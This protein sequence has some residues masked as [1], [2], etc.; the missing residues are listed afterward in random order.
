MYYLRYR[1]LYH[2]YACFELCNV[3]QIIPVVYFK[4]FSYR[5]QFNIY[6]T[7]FK[8]EAFLILIGEY[9]FH[10]LTRFGYD[11]LVRLLGGNI[12]EFVQNLDSIQNYLRDDYQDTIAP[13]FHCD[14]ESVSD[15]MILHYYSHRP[16]YHPL[17]RGK[18][19]II[20]H[21][22]GHHPFISGLEIMNNFK[23]DW[24]I[25]ET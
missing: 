11:E 24:K 5:H 16:G 4:I 1:Y 8:R 22:S 13:S 7:G 14:E 19:Y 2:Y 25:V 9:I 21:L 17:I 12:L 20:L 3:V 15:R 10:Y 6:A 18:W 23:S